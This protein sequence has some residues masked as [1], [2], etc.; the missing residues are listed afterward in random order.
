[1]QSHE[2]LLG[3]LDLFDEERPE[4]EF[5]A[6]LG[7]L[8]FSR[9]TLYRYLKVLTDAGLLSSFPGRGYSLGPRIIQMDYQIIVSDPLIRAARPV[10]QA[11]TGEYRSVGL[12]CRRY[13]Q[14]VLCVHQESSTD[15]VRSNFE[16]GRSRPLLKG[17]A[18]QVI[19]AH[20]SPY[21]LSR[22]YEESP[23]AFAEAGLGESLSAVRARLKEMRHR[24]W[25]HTVAAVTPGV[26]GVAT[27]LFDAQDEVTG[28]LSLTFP[29]TDLRDEEIAEIGRRL[30]DAAGRVGM[31]L[32][33]EP[34]P[35]KDTPVPRR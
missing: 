31:A 35:A 23:A 11:L 2:K 16:R 10:M 30:S 12:L 28:S 15:E 17:A 3:I 18:S 9:S 32:R 20:L 26:T 7:R 25:H 5:D 24:G 8:G 29:R 4:W 34:R 6:M 14:G 27:A 19:L 1:M 22:L 13:R 33:E 21:Q